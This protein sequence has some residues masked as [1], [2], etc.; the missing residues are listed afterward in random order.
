LC[1]HRHQAVTARTATNALG[2]GVAASPNAP[3]RGESGLRPGDFE[4]AD[5]PT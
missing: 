2:R 1:R 3:R 4:D 5:L